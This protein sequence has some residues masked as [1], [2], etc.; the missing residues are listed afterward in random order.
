M[1]IFRIKF[2]LKLAFLKTYVM[3]AQKNRLIESVF[4]HPNEMFKLKDKFLNIQMKCLNWRI[5]F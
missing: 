1:D 4:E 2:N 5:S 3:G